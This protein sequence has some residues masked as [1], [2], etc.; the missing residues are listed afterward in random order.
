M[1]RRYLISLI[2]YITGTDFLEIMR[3][4]N[5]VI[6][7][8]QLARHIEQM[9][10][11][12]PESWK[13]DAKARFGRRIG[14]YAITHAKKP[15][16]VIETDV[17]KGLGACVITAALMKNSEE[18]YRGYYYGTD[19]NTDAGYLLAHLTAP[20]AKCCIAIL[21]NRCKDCVSRSTF[22]SMIV[23]TLQ[24]MKKENTKLSNLSLLVPRLSLVIMT[25][26][27]INSS[28]LRLRRADNSSFFRNSRSTTGILGVV[29]A[30]PFFRDIDGEPFHK[31]EFRRHEGRMIAFASYDLV[32]SSRLSNQVVGILS[33]Q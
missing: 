30:S 8:Q 15:K 13:A 32:G 28:I 16:V 10:T 24:N 27:Q 33:A 21:L 25:T 19:I 17:D 12:S 4:V 31:P 11:R 22:L 3:Y 9:T 26:R 20:L 2:A 5:E 6:E 14:W 7:D 1:N 18:G 23:T 29:L